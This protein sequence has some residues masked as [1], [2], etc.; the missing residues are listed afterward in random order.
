MINIVMMKGI[1]LETKPHNYIIGYVWISF[2]S[3]VV[4]A[5]QIK[6]FVS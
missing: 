5:I 2:I 6:T 4:T 1:K 3:E